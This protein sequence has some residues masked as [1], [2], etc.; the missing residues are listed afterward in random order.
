MKATLTLTLP[1]F[2][3]V[4]V[5]SNAGLQF[6]QREFRPKARRRFLEASVREQGRLPTPSC[7]LLSSGVRWLQAERERTH[8]PIFPRELFISAPACQVFLRLNRSR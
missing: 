3:K 6:R 5:H 7:L 2:R 8:S 4:P 1:F